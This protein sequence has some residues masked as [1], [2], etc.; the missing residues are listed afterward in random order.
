MQRDFKQDLQS[1]TLRTSRVADRSNL[2]CGFV[3]QLRDVGGQRCRHSCCSELRSSNG[4][5]HLGSISNPQS[6]CLQRRLVLIIQWKCLYLLEA[7]VGHVLRHVPN[8]CR[9]HNRH[10]HRIRIDCVVYAL[11]HMQGLEEL[12]NA[13]F[14]I[15][16]LNKRLLK[17]N[18]KSMHFVRHFNTVKSSG[19]ACVFFSS[20]LLCSSSGSIFYA[21]PIFTLT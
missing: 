19:K 17:K 12:P 15:A 5:T 8:T 4:L 18:I 20:N 13:T 1:T 11:G 3:F 6:C 2:E 10:R 7:H 16:V 9:L 21:K 14:A